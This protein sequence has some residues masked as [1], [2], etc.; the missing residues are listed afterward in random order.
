MQETKDETSYFF[1][2][3]SGDPTYYD[4]KGN[5]IVGNPGCSKILLLGFV[6]TIDARPIRLAL[7]SLRKRIDP[8]ILD[9]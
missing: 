6:K 5:L 9:T 1:V 2:D 7:E 8:L 4:R 3:E